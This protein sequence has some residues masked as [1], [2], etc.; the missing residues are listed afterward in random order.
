MELK[1]ERHLPLPR[2]KVWAALNDPDVLRACI[3]GCESF[4]RTDDNTYDAV[5]KAKVGPVSARF[6]GR[7]TLEDLNPPESYSMNFQGQGGQA[8]FV[9]G[10][11]N[12]HLTAADGGCTLA[13]TAKATLGGKLAQLGSRLIDGAARKTADEF[14][15]NFVAHMGGSG[16]ASA[17]PEHGDATAAATTGERN[18]WPWVAAGAGVVLVLLALALL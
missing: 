9:K 16:E 14:F 3:P 11:A 4:D 17:A 12:V 8:G 13:Y 7:V 2:E 18:I 6:K 10:S 5:V 1:Q 15:D